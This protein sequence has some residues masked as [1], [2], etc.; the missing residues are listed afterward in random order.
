MNITEDNIFIKD[1]NHVFSG[2][3][4]ALVDFIELL[5]KSN[6]LLG[7]TEYDLFPEEYADI[8]YRQGKLVF[9]GIPLVHEFYDLLNCTGN[10]IWLENH[11]FPIR[12]DN[13]TIIGVLGIAS[14]ITQ[15]KKANEA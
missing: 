12:D 2:V 1:C 6:R 3:S 13:D 15:H 5:K 7:N 11:Q 9:T 8:L 14:P 10:I 4:K